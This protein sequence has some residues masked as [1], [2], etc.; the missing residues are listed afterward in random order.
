MA[1]SVCPD[2][3]TGTL[4]GDAMPRG[5]DFNV[6]GLPT[7]VVGPEPGV[8][9]LGVVVIFC[10]AFGWKLLNTRALADTYAQRVPCTVYVP[11]IMAGHAPPNTFM[12]LS[13]S[14]PPPTANVLSKLA[15]RIWT[16][17]RILPMLLRF[18]YHNRASVVQPRVHAFIH[19]VRNTTPPQQPGKPGKVAVA[20][21]CWG[22]PFA[23]RLTH[24][25][26]ENKTTFPSTAAGSSQADD[27]AEY[28]PLVDCAFTAH[29]AQLSVPEDVQNVVQPLSVAN[30]DDD[31][32]MGREKMETLKR[33]LEDKNEA[34][35]QEVHEVQVYPGAKHGF[36][37]RGDREDP[38]QRERGY[39]SED[40]AVRWFRRHFQVGSAT[41]ARGVSASAAAVAGAT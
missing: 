22:G 41:T 8:R 9:P 27:E 37:V 26:P 5:R 14:K 28:Y 35:G 10:D 18:V 33:V 7:Y 21:F 38:Q 1:P 17:L 19:S 11:D 4:R 30:G 13:E 12:T 40:Q 39:R 15:S 34:L 20:G 29:P 36:A 23:V 3:F 2:C 31:E 25:I 24:D 32:W 16:N 6:H